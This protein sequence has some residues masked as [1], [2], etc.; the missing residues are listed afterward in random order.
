MSCSSVIPGDV[1]EEN[2]LVLGRYSCADLGRISRGT[3]ES[4]V[5]T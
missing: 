4:M 5:A 1:I 2:D 3:E